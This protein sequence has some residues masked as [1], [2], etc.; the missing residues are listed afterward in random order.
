MQAARDAPSIIEDWSSKKAGTEQ[1]LKLL[2]TYKDLGDAKS[3]VRR[4]GEAW[5]FV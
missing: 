5:L 1:L 2:Q 3:E 4:F